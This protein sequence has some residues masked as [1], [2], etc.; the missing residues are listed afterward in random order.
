MKYSLGISPCP[1]DTFIFDALLHNKI[2]THGIEFELHLAD[3]E[4][5][6]QWALE[7]KLDIT[8][9]SFPALF[10]SLHHYKLLLSGAALGKGVGP[11][12]ISKKEFQL[13]KIKDCSIAIPGKN[14]TANFLLHFALPNANNK[15]EFIFSEIENAVQCQQVDCGVII[16]ENRF[17]YLEKGLIKILDLGE[18]WEQETKLPIPLGGIAIKTSLGNNVKNI[19]NKCIFDSVTYAMNRY[20]Y[21]SDFVLTNAQEMNEDVMRK[22]IDLYVNHYT[23]LLNDNAKQA[24]ETMLKY[25]QKTQ[26]VVHQNFEEIF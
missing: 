25:Y 13:Q 7:G 24:I 16:H 12:L 11:L 1:N 10:K 8:K 5:L 14:T 22:H 15:I 26:M 4:T 20:P 18:Y 6:N 17:T 2:N 23:Q 3:V 19:I 21:L 9:L